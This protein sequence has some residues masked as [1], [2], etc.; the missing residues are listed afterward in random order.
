MRENLHVLQQNPNSSTSA[1]TI[2]RSIEG[3]YHGG[4]APAVRHDV[5]EDAQRPLQRRLRDEET[6]EEERCE[7]AHTG[8]PFRLEWRLYMRTLF[9]T[10]S[11]ADHGGCQECA[12]VHSSAIVT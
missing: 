7:P 5:H 1:L 12:P 10:H 11:R 3:K 2:Q 9:S 4:E 8:P 6:R